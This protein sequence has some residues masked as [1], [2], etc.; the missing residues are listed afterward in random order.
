M[1]EYNPEWRSN[2]GGM[3]Y[4]YHT[5]LWLLDGPADNLITSDAGGQLRHPR[6]TASKFTST[7]TGFPAAHS[8]R[9]GFEFKIFDSDN[10]DPQKGQDLY[11]DAPFITY[12]EGTVDWDL[13]GAA[14]AI[15]YLVTTH[16]NITGNPM[17]ITSVRPVV[18]HTHTNEGGIHLGAFNSVAVLRDRA[19]GGGR[20]GLE[21]HFGLLLLLISAS[22]TEVIEDLVMGNTVSDSAVSS[23]TVAE[24][25]M[26]LTGVT[27]MQLGIG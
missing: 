2:P 9:K 17:G 8:T 1:S 6:V 13:L 16:K 18:G 11:E 27:F 26:H 24:M 14:T 3:T 7:D 23:A 22:V 25:D 4:L 21:M 19:F 20:S 10:I 15:P 12:F 5:P